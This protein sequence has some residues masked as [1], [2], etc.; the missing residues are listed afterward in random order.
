[1]SRSLLQLL[2]N[3]SLVGGVFRR[4]EEAERLIRARFPVD[5]PAGIF[6]LLM[7]PP[8]FQNRPFEL[9]AAHARELV[10]RVAY[11]AALDL[12]TDAEVL[13]ALSGQ[14]LKA[15]LNRDGHL[16]METLF[17]RIFPGR[18][19]AAPPPESFRGQLEELLGEL[20]RRLAVRERRRVQVDA[21]GRQA[22]DAA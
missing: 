6:K 7:P 1:M 10:D 9:Y 8:E 11:G 5:E 12:A 4:I 18:M 13:L 15:P 2:P 16:V 22:V 3:E 20:R 17:A 19:D 21:R 14:S